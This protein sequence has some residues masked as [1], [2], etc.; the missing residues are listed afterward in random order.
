MDL[1]KPLDIHALESC[2]ALRLKTVFRG[3]G[4]WKI[5]LNLL[6]KEEKYLS[7]ESFAVQRP[8]SIWEVS[9]IKFSLENFE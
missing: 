9:L 2:L 1:R 4:L 7:T 5:L 3:A 8:Q 6:S